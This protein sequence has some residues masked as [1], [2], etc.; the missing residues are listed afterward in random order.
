[1]PSSQKIKPI[2]GYRLEKCQQFGD[3]SFIIDNDGFI[4]SNSTRYNGDLHFIRLEDVV[5]I[6]RDGNIKFY[7]GGVYEHKSIQVLNDG[8]VVKTVKRWFH[9]AGKK[10]IDQTIG[11]SMVFF[12][13]LTTG[14]KFYWNTENTEDT[15]VVLEIGED[16]C[17]LLK[18]K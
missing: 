7:R 1:M 10:K 16:E 8:V 5:A 17:Q 9:M 11:K 12:L 13:R 15:S 3:S 2:N 14:N 18:Q 6:M 4:Y